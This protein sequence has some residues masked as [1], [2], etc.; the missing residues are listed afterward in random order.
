MGYQATTDGG[1]TWWTRALQLKWYY[2]VAGIL[3]VSASIAGVVTL[4]TPTP[5][6]HN[7]Y[8]DDGGYAPYYPP[9][10]SP[11]PSPPSPSPSPSPSPIS[12]DYCASKPCL[13]GG[14]CTSQSVSF[15]CTCFG[16]FGGTRCETGIYAARISALYSFTRFFPCRWL[17]LP[18]SLPAKSMHEWRHLLS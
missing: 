6:H 3:L 15:T 1:A 9:S 4:V 12:S 11:S 17:A 16:T 13:N 7:N 2:T 10:P 8:N 14:W 5:A 18:R